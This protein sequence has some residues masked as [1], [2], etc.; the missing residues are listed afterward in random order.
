[1][2]NPIVDA[3]HAVIGA[4]LLSNRVLGELALEPGHFYDP[5][6]SYVFEAMR[7]VAEQGKP[8]DLVTVRSELGRMGRLE[9]CEEYL[10]LAALRVP[11]EANARFYAA[12][13][14]DAALSRRIQMRLS[15]VLERA[16]R[17]DLTGSELL[18]CAMA[19]LSGIDAEQPDE[20]ATI[21]QLVKRRLDELGKLIDSREH[22]DLGLTGAPTGCARLDRLVGGWQYGIVSLVAARPGMGKSSLG[23]ATADASTKAG[24][25]AHLFSLEDSWHAYADRAMSRASNVPA[26]DIRSGRFTRETMSK[27]TL[28]LND[29]GRRKGWLVDN[30][31][32]ITADEIV[33]SVRRHAREN[34][35]RLVLVDY[36]QLV[37]RP[38]HHSTHE[39]LTQVVETLADAA[40]QDGMAYVV[41]SQLNRGVEQ[42]QD[43]RPQLSDLRESGSLEE[44]AKCVVGIYRGAY[45]HSDPI[46]G[47]DYDE[48]G[49]PPHDFASQV[50]LCVIK[51]S[52]GATGRVFASWDGPT[53]RME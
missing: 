53:L 9:A 21:G 31:S 46:P 37:K 5:R 45:Y 22:G 24:I 4:V 27:V 12:E 32:G 6:G 29:I 13:V 35:T 16:K 23:L 48:P 39:E 52:N 7:G 43:K 20:A 33:R 30:R 14:K 1:M 28:G 17:A 40:K 41:M 3:E 2:K 18:S 36:V 38:R 51:N 11:D 19:A 42:R 26:E 25:G 10:G 34:G 15:D 49:P 44:R 50:Q 8:V 47:I